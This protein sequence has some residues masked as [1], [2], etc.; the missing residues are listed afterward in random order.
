MLTLLFSCE[1]VINVWNKLPGETDFSLF[2]KFK[3][4]ITSM[5]WSDYLCCF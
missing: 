1:R 2:S 3:R 4:T 5:D